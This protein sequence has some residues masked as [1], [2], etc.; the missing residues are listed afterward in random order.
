MKVDLGKFTKNR[1]RKLNIRVDNWDT[2]SLDHTLALIILPSLIQLKNQMYGIP[3]EFY[4]GSDSSSQY[5][6]DFYIEGDNAACDLGVASWN[7]TLDKMIWSFQQ[8]S[9]EDYEDKYYHGT[10]EIDWKPLEKDHPN[11]DPTQEF[12][13]MI[14]KNPDEHWYDYVGN[15]L[16][17]ERI[18]EGVDLF[19]KYFRSLWS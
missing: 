11:Y 8:I 1:F 6:F 16:H 13:E 9:L 2:Y 18:Q 10:P 17:D 19:A 3:N 5:A 12:V 14:D 15:Q 4:S 7:A